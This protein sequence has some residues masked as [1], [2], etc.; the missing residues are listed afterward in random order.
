MNVEAKRGRGKLKKRLLD[1]IEND[2][3]TVGL[4]VGDVENRDK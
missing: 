3:R 1:T 4:C 2:M